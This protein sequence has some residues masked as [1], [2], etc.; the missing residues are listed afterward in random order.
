MFYT[1]DYWFKLP[2]RL[3]V[4]NN[5]TR[6]YNPEDSSEQKELTKN[7]STD[8]TNFRHLDAM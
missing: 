5:T 6:Q 1:A 2:C 3:F 7:I 4:Q 8:N